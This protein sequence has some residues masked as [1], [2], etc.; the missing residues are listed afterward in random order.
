MEKKYLAAKDSA[1]VSFVYNVLSGSYFR[2]GL[3]EK[4]RYYQLKSIAFLDDS[5]LDYGTVLS[6]SLL[7]ISGKVNRYAVLGNYYLNENKPDIAEIYLKEAMNYYHQLKSPLLMDDVPF[8]F[9]NWPVANL[10]AKR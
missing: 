5:Q 6:A 8:S 9:C 4:C 3:I 7:G 10:T 1:A 2:I